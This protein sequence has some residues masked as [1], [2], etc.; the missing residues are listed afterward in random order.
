M[1]KRLNAISAL[2]AR[3]GFEVAELQGAIL[4]LLY[5]LWIIYP[6]PESASLLA[7]D[8]HSASFLAIG[9]GQLL[10]M[11]QHRYWLRR[12]MSLLAVLIWVFTAFYSFEPVQLVF[13]AI[14][15]WGF[16]R[17]SRRGDQSTETPKA[18]KKLVGMA[19]M[20]GY[21]LHDIYQ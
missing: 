10:G 17:I 21:A 3:S 5:G 6:T 16:L 11:M 1:T 8:V 15:G 9:S 18:G 13:A 4:A 12:A 19:H 20:R 2:A 14:A 7:V